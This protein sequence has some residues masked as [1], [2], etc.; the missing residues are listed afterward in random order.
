L[1]GVG[2]SADVYDAGD[3]KVLRRYR[4]EGA[5][6]TFEARVMRHVRDHGYPVPEVFD[7]AGPDLVMERV[8]GPTMLEALGKRPWTIGRSAA[9]LADLH[10][11]LHAIPAPDWLP[12]AFGGG[13]ALLHLDLHPLNVLLTSDGPVVID[14]PNTRRGPA[15]GDVAHSWVVLATAIPSGR[16][17]QALASIGRRPLLRGF[18]GRYPRDDLLQVMPL[19]AQRWLADRN[20]GERERRATLDLLTKLGLNLP[21]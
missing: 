10:D 7:A 14:W 2:R 11:R 20:V 6:A 5:D 9:L 18:L 15:L 1:I 4:F 17:D 8:T 21:E 19:V 12:E 13:E 16:F 3:G